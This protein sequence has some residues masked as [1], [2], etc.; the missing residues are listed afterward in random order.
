[1]DFIRVND[2]FVQ[3]NSP[4]VLRCKLQ[5]SSL[6]AGL[7]AAANSMGGDFWRPPGQVQVHSQVPTTAPSS[8]EWFTS[9]GFQISAGEQLAR[10]KSQLDFSRARS[11]PLFLFLFLVLGVVLSRW[12]AALHRPAT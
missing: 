5:S 11:L 9:D 10:G 12:E 4:A 8:I 6:G 7:Q 1:M 3:L 2:E